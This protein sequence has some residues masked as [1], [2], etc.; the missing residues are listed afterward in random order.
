MH[1]IDCPDLLDPDLNKDNMEKLKEQLV[2]QCSS[3]LSSVL[4]TVPLEQ[5]FSIP[6]LVM[7]VI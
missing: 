5:Q 6:L 1:V 4:I 2:S 7:L 3:G